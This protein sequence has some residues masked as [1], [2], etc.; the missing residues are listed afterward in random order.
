[1]AKVPLLSADLDLIQIFLNNFC[2]GSTRLSHFFLYG[3]RE[4]WL[5]RSQF[6]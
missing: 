3:N 4:L 1:M 6:R 2:H 5:I